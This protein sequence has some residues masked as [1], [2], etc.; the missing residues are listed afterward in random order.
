MIHERYTIQRR[1]GMGGFGTVY[2]AISNDTGLFVAIKK[3]KGSFTSWEE[4]I[5][6]KEVESLQ[7]LLH[8]SLIRLLEVIREDD[9][10]YMVF[11]YA[12]NLNIFEAIQQRREPPSQNTIKQWTKEI[13]EALAYVH[14]S[15]YFHRDIKPENVLL[16]GN[17]IKIADFGLARAVSTSLDGPYTEYVSTRWYRA[18]EVLLRSPT[19]GPPIDI[20]AV[21]AMLAELISRK[22]LFPG[23]SEI[24]QIDQITS[25][26][27]SPSTESWPEGIELARNVHFHFR[28]D[29]Q[30]MTAEELQHFLFSNFC[31][32]LSE[33]TRG[34]IAN[35]ES[36]KYT[37]S[38][39]SSIHDITSKPRNDPSHGANHIDYDTRCHAS[40]Y[41]VSLEACSLIQWM[42]AWDPKK[43]P[44]ARQ[45]LQHPYFTGAVERK[46]LPALQHASL[47]RLQQRLCMASERMEEKSKIQQLRGT[48]DDRDGE[49]DSNGRGVSQ[50]S[51]N[52]ALPSTPELR[53]LKL[54]MLKRQHNSLLKQAL[55]NHDD[56]VTMPQS[57]SS[58]S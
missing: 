28:Q 14:E 53:K 21:G 1:L 55:A 35:E 37:H 30:S 3:M 29:A 45:A 33:D 5:K 32:T 10:L 19:Y 2:Q 7:K 24:N 11:E 57:S 34:S 38:N 31:E 8:P 13:L 9:T 17:K 26:M 42:C 48:Y 40:E 12:D 41:I 15:G 23:T 50:E 58:S 44:T 56:D 46:K 43:R 20:F 52:K 4:C 27:G 54:R 16:H 22:P 36:N 6:L 47:I 18:P 25:I 51:R 49:E 39:P